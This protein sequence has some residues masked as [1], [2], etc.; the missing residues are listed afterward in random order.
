[1]TQAPEAPAP[2]QQ[3]TASNVFSG[4]WVWN[5]ST[6]VPP[7]NGQART[8]TGVGASSTTINLSCKESS[9]LDLRANIAVIEIGD[10]LRVQPASNPAYWLEYTVATTPVFAA[11]PGPPPTPYYAIGVVLAGGY[12]FDPQPNGALLTMNALGNKAYQQ[13]LRDTAP[14]AVMDPGAI[15]RGDGWTSPNT[16]EP[17]PRHVIE[18]D[19]LRAVNAQ[20]SPPAFLP[21]NPG[22]PPERALAP[23]GKEYSQQLRDERN[24]A[25]R[26]SPEEPAA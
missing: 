6:S 20:E 21:G 1:M 25:S 18:R 2:E 12:N 26:P 15:P 14:T 16:P 19:N 13:W 7:A 8:N 5:T 4:T 23:G 24:E 3:A 9:G 11:S 10:S 22:A 17:Q